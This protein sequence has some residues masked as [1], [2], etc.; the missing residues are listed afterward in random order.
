MPDRE[1]N[2]CQDFQ[3]FLTIGVVRLMSGEKILKGGSWCKHISPTDI[4]V[5][6]F[7]IQIRRFGKIWKVFG[8]LFCCTPEMFI[9]FLFILFLNKEGWNSIL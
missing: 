2:V 1:P 9:L 3:Y 4:E 8:D 5:F 7:Y 6:I